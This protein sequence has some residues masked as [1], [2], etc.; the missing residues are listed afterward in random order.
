MK[1]SIII[2]VKD[3]AGLTE[4]CLKSIKE[5]TQDYEIII[6]DNGSDTA[7]SGEGII[8][9]N[10]ENL[11]FPKAVN[12]GIA[13]AKGEIIVILNND[14]IVTPN[15]IENLEAHFKDYD[16]VGPVTNSISGPQKIEA[17]EYTG[18]NQ[19]YDFARSYN[20]QHKEESMPFHRLVFF[21]IA[22]KRE[23]IDKVGLLDEQFTPGNFEDDDYCLRAIEAGFRLGIAQDVF[24]HH[25][26]GATHKT[27]KIDFK[28]LMET[29]FDKFV[30]KWPEPKIQD[31]KMKNY[32]NCEEQPVENKPSIALVMIVKNEEKGLERAILSCKDFVKEIIIA[33]DDSSEDKTLEIA[34]KHATRVKTFKW[35]NDFA[36]ARND[37]AEGVETDWILFIDG[38]EFVEKY[39]GLEKKLKSDKDA[40]L[41]TVELDSGAQI[42]SP[43]I[44]RNGIKFNGEYHEQVENKTIEL[45]T[46]FLIKHDRVGGQEIKSQMK[47]EIMRDQLLPRVMQKQVNKNKRNTRALFHLALYEQ[48]RGNFKKALKWQKKYFRYAKVKNERWYV[49]FNRALCFLALGKNFRAFWTASRAENE[50]PGRWETDKLKGLIFFQARKYEK[51]IES[52]VK[53]F[54]IN[55]G[56]QTYKPWKRD[57][58]GT[59]NLIGESWFNLKQYFKAHIAFEQAWK[60]CVNQKYKKML[61]DRQKL[62]KDMAKKAA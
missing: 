4:N 62:M 8:I 60:K 25:M 31:L 57:D 17:P 61:Y 28:M 41:C 42:R 6:V 32:E 12:Q 18:N 36:K 23:V 24:I 48:S 45:F 53:S 37:A 54:H 9:R 39:D 29:N 46:E 50:S 51:A 16:M 26:G 27:L 13:A 1:T 56:D 33:V 40:L 19:L 14:T 11:G 5:N 30:M 44:Y 34:Q 7:Y 52:L 59:W 2:P 3:N 22:I 15:W 49:Y 10:E 21:C 43:R 38:H 35:E 58:S 55:T 20:E 47:R